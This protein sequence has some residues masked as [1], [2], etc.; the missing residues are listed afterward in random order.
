LIEQG[1]FFAIGFLV[2][3]LAAVAATPVLARRATRLAERRA[4]L[5]APATEKQ[6]MAERDALRALHAVEY[7][8]LV[9]RLA[10]AEDVS[11]AL[12][13]EVGRQ[14]V[15]LFA[16]KAD[17]G[18]LDS[19]LSEQRA[20]NER[21][22]RR[23]HDLEATVAASQIAL[24][25][26]FGQRDRALAAEAAANARETERDAETSRSRARSAILMARAENLET[27]V[28]ELS[29]SVTTSADQAKR[30]VTQLAEERRRAAELDQR[31]RQ[32]IGRLQG[33]AEDLSKMDAER[34]A[35]MRKLAEM[36]KRLQISER[37]R[38]EA[39]RESGS[40]LAAL[41]DRESALKAALSK[42]AELE[43]R[44]TS[45]AAELSAREKTGSFLAEAPDAARSEQEGFEQEEGVLQSKGGALRATQ[46]DASDADLRESIARLGREVSRLF[47][48]QRADSDG[49]SGAGGNALGRTQAAPMAPLPNDEVSGAEETPGTRLPRARR[50]RPANTA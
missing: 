33:A 15:Q 11:T 2:A 6:A 9:R 7:V 21:T 13:A 12:R 43:T 22:A 41:E 49:A 14:S 29:S 18:A 23:A 38:E 37:D 27:R 17:F 40:R 20:E 16:L 24:H 45:H 28:A 1:L 50:R 35:L 39:T 26:V 31:L 34:N 46:H 3:A 8:R 48:A 42:T 10:Q 4:K 19:E 5:R 30:A 44:T 25:D 32:T 36:E 47:A